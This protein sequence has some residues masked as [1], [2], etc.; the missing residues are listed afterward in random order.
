[1]EAL[2]LRSLWLAVGYGIVALITW[3]SL[4]SDP[5]TVDI[6]VPWQDKVFHTL[7]YFVLMLWFAQIYRAMPQRGWCVLGCLALGAAMEVLQ[8]FNPARTMELADMLANASGV[9][10]ALLLARAGLDG[11]LLRLERLL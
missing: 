2:R 5:V 4:T 11:L 7:A 10:L 8:G 3:L 1:M 9:L 6:D